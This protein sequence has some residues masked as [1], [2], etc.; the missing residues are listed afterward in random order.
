MTATFFRGLSMLLDVAACTGQIVH[1]FLSA[2]VTEW[3]ATSGGYFHTRTVYLP[4][5]AGPVNNQSA[6]IGDT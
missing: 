1:G 4:Y 5:G 3:A 2:A 6:R